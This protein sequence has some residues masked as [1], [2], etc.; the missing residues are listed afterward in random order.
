MPSEY[1]KFFDKLVGEE[2]VKCKICGGKIGYKDCSTKGMST[3]IKAMHKKEFAQLN[4]SRSA[5]HSSDESHEPPK[6]NVLL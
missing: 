1:W 5:V 4:K 2:K 3:H 6:V